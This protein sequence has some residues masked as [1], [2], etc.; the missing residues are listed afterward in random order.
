MAS[1]TEEAEVKPTASDSSERPKFKELSPPE[2]VLGLSGFRVMSGLTGGAK[3][4]AKVDN[5]NNVFTI[6]LPRLFY[7]AAYYQI[8]LELQA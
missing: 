2:S 8:I 6:V 5:K 4:R 1:C 3:I 7:K